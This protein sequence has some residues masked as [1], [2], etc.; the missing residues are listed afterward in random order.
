M[1]LHYLVKHYV[2]KQALNDSYNVVHVATYLT[3]G[4]VVNN[5]IRKGLLL[6]L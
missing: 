4:G 5:H 6:S 1:F 3:C 2:S